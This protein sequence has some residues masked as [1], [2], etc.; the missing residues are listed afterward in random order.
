MNKNLIGISTFSNPQT[1]RSLI[2]HPSVP[3]GIKLSSPG[4]YTLTSSWEEPIPANGP[5]AFYE[6]QYQLFTTSQTN[7]IQFLEVSADVFTANLTGLMPQSAYSISIRA[8]NRDEQ[9]NLLIGP[10]SQ[11]ILGDTGFQAPSNPP[12]IVSVIATSSKSIE[13]N[14]IPAD[15][16]IAAPVTSYIIFIVSVSQVIPSAP[17]PI[18]I[19]ALF[20]STEITGLFPYS[21]YLVSM[22]SSN[23]K[24]DSSPGSESSVTTE[25]DI[26]TFPAANITIFLVESTV[27]GLSWEDP[28]F[29]QVRGEIVRYDIHYKRTD[30][31]REFDII[32]ATIKNAMISGLDAYTGYDVSVAIVTGKGSGPRNEP[33]I[34]QRTAEG[35]PTAPTDLVADTGDTSA[36]LIWNQPS[37]INGLLQQYTVTIQD[38]ISDDI[39]VLTLPTS[40][41]ITEPYLLIDGLIPG[42]N[43]IFSVVASTGAGAGVSSEVGYFTTSGT[44]PTTPPPLTVTVT[45]TVPVTVTTVSTTKVTTSTTQV[46]DATTQSTQTTSTTE[47]ATLTDPV[48]NTTTNTSSTPTVTNSTTDTST[49]TTQS[50]TNSLSTPTTTTTQPI[51]GQLPNFASIL[52]PSVIIVILLILLVLVLI[53][54]GVYVIRNQEHKV[55]ARV[56]KIR[57]LTDTGR[58]RSSSLGSSRRPHSLTLSNPYHAIS[59]GAASSRNPQSERSWY[60]SVRSPTKSD[61]MD[62]LQD[63]V[64]EKERQNIG[65]GNLFTPYGYRPPALGAEPIPSP[66]GMS[67]LAGQQ[68]PEVK[69]NRYSQ[70]GVNIDR[71]RKQLSSPKESHNGGIFNFDKLSPKKSKDVRSDTYAGSDPPSL[72]P[73]R[74]QEEPTG[75]RYV[76]DE[77]VFD[78]LEGEPE[79]DEE[80]RT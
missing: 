3:R 23:S 33:P 72:P 46:T 53:C 40:N 66:A 35:L 42:S 38:I 39:L 25:E 41:T 70:E 44:R 76:L 68:T 4:P 15:E 31:N 75:L 34:V 71:E 1:I 65:A 27:I 58:S 74:Y 20:N 37:S 62:A 67:M 54:V 80:F 69:S 60:T 16:D 61:T 6:I 73:R 79:R 9:G 64:A 77:G 13:I 26:P 47:T 78:D 18:E 59:R 55:K 11:V 51:S 8:K 43:Y 32:R 12:T 21:Q 17:T 5:V 19:S 30:E 48:T 57:G 24:G 28:H 36:R 2:L 45:V 10:F 29:I 56:L 49:I 63:L 14:W 52:I 7:Q 22:A 50:D